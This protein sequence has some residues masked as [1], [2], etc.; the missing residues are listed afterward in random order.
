MISTSAIFRSQIAHAITVT[1]QITATVRRWAP[2]PAEI[3]PESPLWIQT[4]EIHPGDEV[5]VYLGVEEGDFPLLRL[6][7]GSALAPFPA[8]GAFLFRNPTVDRTRVAQYRADGESFEPI[9]QAVTT[10]T[11]CKVFY[12]E[13][14]VNAR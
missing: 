13:I 2:L 3:S 8:K 14:A 6:N 5:T 10:A 11:P 9:L 7:G 12:L 1:S 4:G